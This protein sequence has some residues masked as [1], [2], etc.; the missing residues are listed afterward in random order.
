MAEQSTGSLWDFSLAVYRDAAVQK[1]CLSLQDSHGLDVNILLLC[2]WLAARNKEI[3]D[4][5]MNNLLAATGDW[6]STVVVP[7]RAIRR[8]MK[9]GVGQTP[10]ETTEV[11]RAR[12]KT[13]E[14]EA[15]RI[16]Q[17]QL[18]AAVACQALEAKD[19]GDYANTAM[20]NLQTYFS[21]L[22]PQPKGDDTGNVELLV[23]ESLRL[24]PLVG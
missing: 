14:L 15:E 7:L 17:Q 22:Q 16:E 5:G 10:I 13:L 4:T 2:C 20:A 1:A 11:L 23:R 9:V 24:A 12:I 21:A 19:A 8:A 3:D 6:Q 18:E